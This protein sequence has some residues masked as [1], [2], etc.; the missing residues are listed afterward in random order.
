ME[1]VHETGGNEKVEKRRWESKMV[2]EGK[3]RGKET[4]SGKRGQVIRVGW[5]LWKTCPI[6]FKVWDRLQLPIR[7]LSMLRSA[8]FERCYLG[9]GIKTI[10][11][12]V[13]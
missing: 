3:E 1:I 12:K 6:R 2:E 5:S 8:Q 7:A 13:G 9:D 11:N 4:R 10:A